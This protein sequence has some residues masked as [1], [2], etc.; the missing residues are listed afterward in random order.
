[1]KN[2][3]CHI[4]E[5]GLHK[6]WSRLI[7]G[8][9]L[10]L[11]GA[12]GWA[13]GAT[14]DAA[15]ATA[16]TA[17][18]AHRVENAVVQIFSTARMPDLCKPWS[19][20]AAKELTG[21][22]VVIEGKRILTNAHLVLYASQIQ[23]QANQSGNKLPASV[24]AVAPGIDLAVLKL[25]DESFFDTHPPLPRASTLPAIKDN[26]MAYGFPVGGTGISITKG[27]VS[28]I[29][30]AG[31]NTPTSGLRIQID[32]AINTG[33]SGGPALVGDQMIG[34]AYSR[35]SSAQNVG[36]IIPC[37]EIDL[38]L[39]DIADG[40][41]DGKY[42]GKPALF[43]EF[44]TFENPALRAFLRLDHTVEGIIVHEIDNPDPAYPLKKWDLITRIG[45]TRIDNEGKI[46]LGDNLRVSF[47][48][49]IQKT[50]KNGKVPLT[51]MREGQALTLDVP[52]EYGRPKLI[53]HLLGT[54]PD[55]FVYG[56][57]V[58]TVATEDFVTLVT[59]IPSSAQGAPGISGA[60]IYNMLSASGSPLVTRRSERATAEE[61]QLVLIPAPFFPHKLTKGYGNPA[62]RVVKNVNGVAI[63]S[64]SHL[65]EVL[66]DAKEQFVTI[67]LAG[68]ATES[69]VLPR[70]EMTAAT[71][72][73]LNDAGIRAQGSPAMLAVWEGKAR[74]D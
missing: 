36:Y 9:V 25:E 38:F 59:S 13:A 43:D 63:K 66:R 22:G 74:G 31:Y 7:L 51:V 45:D 54:Y 50:A 41:Y 30:F 34:I 4:H 53:P 14:A 12:S 26:V 24:E 21:S 16:A 1:M 56:P 55:Y 35:L 3:S 49:L 58:F 40:K 71:E 37:E 20:Q 32:A 46:R 33:N 48:Y 62:A 47:R 8:A 11:A 39:Q 65:V 64:L 44:Q 15:P 18:D 52:V 68:R 5:T 72:G 67:E 73:I 42:D 23:V 2:I 10:T 19:K 6:L 69:L 61:Q 27:I 60:V 17:T 70:K 29:E 57:I 28:R